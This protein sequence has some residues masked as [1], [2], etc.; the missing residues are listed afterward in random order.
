LFF[1][2]YFGLLFL[3]LTFVKSIRKKYLKI[4]GKRL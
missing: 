3:L 4:N 2:K 1:N